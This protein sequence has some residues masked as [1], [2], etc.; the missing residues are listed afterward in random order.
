[1]D[2]WMERKIDRCIGVCVSRYVAM[3]IDKYIHTYTYRYI[4]IYSHIDIAAEHRRSGPFSLTSPGVPRCR[5]GTG[6][7]KEGCLFFFFGGGGGG[8]ARLYGFSSF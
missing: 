8:A 2:G 7:P 4:Q 1:M 6:V 3:R 5:S